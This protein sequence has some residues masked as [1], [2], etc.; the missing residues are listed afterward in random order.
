M[1]TIERNT[2]VNYFAMLHK[3]LLERLSFYFIKPYFY[4]PFFSLIVLASKN[5]RKSLEVV[6]HLYS[7]SQLIYK[8]NIIEKNDQ[9]IWLLS[10]D[11]FPSVFIEYLLSFIIK[12][13]LK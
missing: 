9:Q 4:V 8:I 7:F 2:M 5:G 10:R 6:T 3:I 1:F 13:S 12:L 11:V